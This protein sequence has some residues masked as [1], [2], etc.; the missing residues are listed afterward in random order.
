MATVNA[1]GVVTAT[2]I[3]RTTISATSTDGSNKSATAD[4]VVGITNCDQY[5]YGP[6]WVA[7]EADITNSN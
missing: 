7:F 4:V 2:G 6:N 5:T 1:S 3:G